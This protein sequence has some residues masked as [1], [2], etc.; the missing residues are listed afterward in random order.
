MDPL[1]HAAV[2]LMGRPLAPKAPVWALVAAT[3]VPDVLFFGF[4]AV[5]LER[6]AATQLDLSRG[7]IYLSQPLIPWSHGL[8]MCVVWSA[9]VG[10]LAHLFF[11]DWRASLVMGL[12]VFSH[13]LLDFTVYPNMPILFGNSPVIGLAGG[14]HR[15]EPSGDGA[16]RRWRLRRS[17]AVES[18]AGGQTKLNSS[19]IPYPFPF[20]LI[21][22]C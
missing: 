18:R 10:G 14:F 21:A 1:A 8:L 2:A 11:R 13:W 12:L 5:G 7:L 20:Q 16:D 17:A 3:Q 9:V 19:F 15:R 4:Q 22:T 6:Q